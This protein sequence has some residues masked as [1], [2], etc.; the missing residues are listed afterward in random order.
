MAPAF[1]FSAITSKRG[2]EPQHE[3][4]AGRRLEVDGDRPLAEVVAQEGGA[5]AAAL[6]VEHRRLRAAPEVAALAGSRPSRRRRRGG[7]AAGW[8]RGAP[9]SARGP[10]RA[11]RRA[12]SRPRPRRRWRRLRGAWT[13]GT[14]ECDDPSDSLVP[15]P[16]GR[17]GDRRRRRVRPAP[18]ARPQHHRRGGRRR[19]R[20]GHPLGRG[21]RRGH[22]HDGRRGRPGRAP[23]APDVEPRRRSGSP[24]P[25]P[26]TPTRPTPPPSTP[27]CASG[28]HVGAFDAVGV[29]ALERGRAVRGADGQR[30][31]PRR[32]RRP[33][34]RPARAVP[35]RPTFGDGAAA[36]LVAD[37]GDAPAARRA[38]RRRPGHRGVP[39]PLAHARRRPLEGVGGA[40]R[41]DPLR[42]PRRGGVGG[43]AEARRAGRRPGR[44][45]RHRRHAQP[46]RRG[47][48][49][50]ARRRATGRSAPTWP[51]RVGNLGAAQ[52]AAL[53]TAALEQA[54]AR[55]GDR[56]RRAG[57]RRRRRRC[58]AP[59]TP[60]PSWAPAPLGRRPRRRRRA[61]RL[62]HL[63]PL[64]RPAHRRAAAPARAG[65]PVGVGGGPLRRLEVRLRRLRRTTPARSTCR[66]S[67]ATP[68]T[69]R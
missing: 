67:P 15:L 19:R 50:A 22:H 24:P 10:A 38:H 16:H 35:T 28:P 44:P 6:R 55:P 14:R 52:P 53:L 65:A 1:E 54:D 63:P 47:A 59:P 13:D 61:D 58:S 56:A 3:V 25:R 41:R 7:R 37:E 64:A 62:R 8:R 42:A 5:D 45:R 9:A 27:P 32:Q 23:S 2:R 36:L 26:P 40:L 34:Q 30:H 46:G 29:G 33:P 17:T 39:R 31:P 43:R 18:A 57:R 69:S 11:R 68:P 21:L 20:Q 48:R 60:S 49:Q 4:A 51:A 66:R 12:A